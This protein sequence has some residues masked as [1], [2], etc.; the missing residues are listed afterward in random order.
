MLQQFQNVD[1]KATGTN[2]NAEEEEQHE[3]GESLR[4]DM[5]VHVDDM[6][7]RSA[8]SPIR[9][10]SNANTSLGLSNSE[11]PVNEDVLRDENEIVK[12]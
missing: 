11:E 2:D 12:L 10:S 4:T 7:T 1:P 9:T 6:R 8:L 5:N 3:Q